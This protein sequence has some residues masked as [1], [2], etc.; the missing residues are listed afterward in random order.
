MRDLAGYDKDKVPQK[1]LKK[2]QPYLNMDD[3][4]PAIVMGKSRAAAGLCEWIIN[5]NEYCKVFKPKIARK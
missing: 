4:T 2:I 3:F 5:T 1:L